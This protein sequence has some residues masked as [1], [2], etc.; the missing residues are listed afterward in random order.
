MIVP[1]W[2]VS[3]KMISLPSVS[4]EYQYEEDLDSEWDDFNRL[5]N[6]YRLRHGKMNTPSPLLGLEYAPRRRAEEQTS[7][8][9]CPPSFMDEEKDDL[10]DYTSTAV[11]ITSSSGVCLEPP[12]CI[13]I[14]LSLFDLWRCLFERIGLALYLTIDEITALHLAASSSFSP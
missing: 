4:E 13:Q 2:K 10:L 11:S 8:Y 7:F 5:M 6:E 14:L 1:V 3:V 9:P 12:K